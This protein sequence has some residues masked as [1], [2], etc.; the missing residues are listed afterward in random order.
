MGE[1]P[2]AC[3]KCGNRDVNDMLV[4]YTARSEDGGR[5]RDTTT[6]PKFLYGLE[7]LSDRRGV[8]QVALPPHRIMK[9]EEYL[10]LKCRP[11]EKIRSRRYGI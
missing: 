11:F 2:M 6:L 5:F 9:V 10:C 1:I 3:A 8:G 7:H 4:R